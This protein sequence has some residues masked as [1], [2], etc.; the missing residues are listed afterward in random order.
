MLILI[1]IE[2]GE[3]DVLDITVSRSAYVRHRKWGEL[4]SSAI[5]RVI[6]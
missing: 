4:N 5:D 6:R 2:L 3:L 1:S